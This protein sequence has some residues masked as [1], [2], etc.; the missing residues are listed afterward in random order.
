MPSADVSLLECQRRL[1]Q[2]AL[3]SATLLVAVPDREVKPGGSALKCK[4]RT[5][6]AWHA[7]GIDTIEGQ[8]NGFEERKRK[9]GWWKG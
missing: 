6:P 3:A 7:L 5:V 1:R 4:S 9:N 8:A 2:S